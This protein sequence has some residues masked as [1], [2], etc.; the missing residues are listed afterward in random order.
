MPD[1]ASAFATAEAERARG[2]TYVHAFDDPPILAGHDTLGLK[3]IADCPDLT[4]VLVS[5]GGGA[6]ISGVATAIKAVK[7][8]VRRMRPAVRSRM[9]GHWSRR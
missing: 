8:S 1:V 5:I 3:F 4:D 7:P 9:C 6:L 2:L